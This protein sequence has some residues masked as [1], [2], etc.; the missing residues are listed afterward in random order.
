M[1]LPSLLH[2][3]VYRTPLDVLARGGLAAAAK[4]CLLYFISRDV[5]WCVLPAC[6]LVYCLALIVLHVVCRSQH[7]PNT[8]FCRPW[9]RQ[10]WRPC[11]AARTTVSLDAC[12]PQT[13]N[14][15]AS[16]DTC[17]RTETCT[18]HTRALKHAFSPM[19]SIHSATSVCRRFYWTDVNLWA[20]DVPSLSLVVLSGRDELMHADEVCA[21]SYFWCFW[22]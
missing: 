22:F 4:A 20:E 17:T 9:P 16:C 19:H 5:H 6:L 7:T 14:T 2:N 8:V 3:F 1:F 12:R 11:H 13:T 10:A 18:L 21:L 15:S